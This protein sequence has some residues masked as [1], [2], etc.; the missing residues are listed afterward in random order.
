MLLGV[1]KKRH[2]PPKHRKTQRKLKCTSPR[3]V[4]WYAAKNEDAEKA[5]PG[6]DRRG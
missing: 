6:R 2:K 1:K 3:E 5:G 4:T